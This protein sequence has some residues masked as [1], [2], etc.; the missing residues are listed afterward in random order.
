[1]EEFLK[2]SKISLSSQ[3]HLS[4]EDISKNF[5]SSMQSLLSKR[6]WEQDKNVY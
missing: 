2:L 5:L 1:M 3:L 6:D 4:Y